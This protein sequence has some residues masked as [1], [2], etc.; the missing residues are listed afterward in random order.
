MPPQVTWLGQAGFLLE[1]AGTRILVDPFLAEHAD[2][3]YPPPGLDGV[4][5]GCDWLF[6][7][8]DHL[9]HL[10]ADSLPAIAARSNARLRVVVPAPLADRVRELA[11]DAEVIPVAPEAGV[12]L[13]A[14]GR[15][16]VVPA[17]HADDPTDGYTEGGGR[18]V[19]YVFELDGVA[20]YHAG[21][22]LVTGAL[23]AIL[24]DMRI[25]VALLPVN[26][27]NWFRERQGLAGN[28]DVREAV[29]VARE[30]GAR[31]L[32]PIHWD[33]FAANGER[34][35]AVVDEVVATDAL[36]HVV[37]LRRELPWV[38]DVAR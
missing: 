17:T 21:D 29:G 25:D 13:G 15:A 35:G 31:V 14:A 33:L 5:S 32:V 23:L 10:D 11:P 38:A 19:G 1:A 6:V 2:R 22:T 9:D 28:M 7:T 24:G 18:Y 30:I 12:E 3:A 20:I 27:R 4:G 37:T 26:G 36:L 8:H 34:P 16:V